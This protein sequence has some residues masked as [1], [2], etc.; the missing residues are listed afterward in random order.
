[1]SSVDRFS[2]EIGQLDVGPSD[3][4]S[5]A[6]CSCMP[7]LNL[8]TNA[9]SGVSSKLSYLRVITN[10]YEGAREEGSKSVAEE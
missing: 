3:W 10:S 6:C 9:A 8:R 7:S 2:R 1:V 5:R 4:L